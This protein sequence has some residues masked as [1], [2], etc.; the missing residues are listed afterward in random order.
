MFYKLIDLDFKKMLQKVTKDTGQLSVAHG[1]GLNLV[2]P[3]HWVL[4]PQN[5]NQERQRTGV[6][7]KQVY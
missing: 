6:K 4:V 7:N 2:S 5:R 3:G 1:P